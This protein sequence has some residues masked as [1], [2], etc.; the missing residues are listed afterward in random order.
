MTPSKLCSLNVRLFNEIVIFFKDYMHIVVFTVCMIVH[1]MHVWCIQRPVESI[2]SL[3]NGN[4]DKG[5]T[6]HRFWK[7]CS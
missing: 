2:K 6:S 5:K 4:R 3:G 7:T 1:H